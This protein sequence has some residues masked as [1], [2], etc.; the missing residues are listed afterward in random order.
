MN[1]LV[2]TDM[3]AR[4]DRAVRR[5]V[6]LATEQNA[7]LTV[8]C[9][10]DD[11]GPDVLIAQMVTQTTAELRR[12]VGSLPGGDAHQVT[13]LAGDPTGSILDQLREMAPDLL[14]LGRHRDRPLRDMIRETTAER[15]VRLT[16]C[17]VLMVVDRVDHTYERV[18]AATDFSP[19]AAAAI[20]LAHDLAPAA[21]IAPV[22][23]Y[24]VPYSGILTHVGGGTEDIAASFRAEAEE[25]DA[26]WRKSF[27]LPTA[28]GPTRTLPG[29]PLEL[30]NSE[31]RRIDAALLCCG[32]HGRAGQARALLGSVATDLMRVPPCDLLIARPG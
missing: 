16:S 30:L 17:P 13:V 27:A 11:A 5:A 8:L 15:L 2:A 25:A 4:S 3:S 6:R 21:S 12:F 29:S 23:S 28:C 31:T 1:F 24:H 20:R 32:A 10:V 19:A 9:I 7:E 14:I 18:I 26:E 22:H